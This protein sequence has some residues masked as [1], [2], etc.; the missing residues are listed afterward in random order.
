[1]DW[2]RPWKMP[3]MEAITFRGRP[4]LSSDVVW[5]ALHIM[6]NSVLDWD[7]DVSWV[8]PGLPVRDKHPW[9][10]FSLAEMMEVLARSLGWSAPGPDH[11][12]WTH[13]K[14]LMAWEEV[15]SLLLWIANACLQMG[16]WLKELKAFKTVVILKPGKPSYNVP[17]TFR[18]I[19]L[20]NMMDKLFEKTIANWL[21][22]EAA[23]EGILHPCQFRGV[24]Q[25][26]TENTEIYLTHLVH[27]E[28]AKG[29]KT[30]MVAFDLAQYFSSLQHRVIITLLKYMGFATQ[31][32]DFFADYL[33]G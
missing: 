3:F 1:M 28:W 13:L 5:S 16:T 10:D 33:V 23:K 9:L 29:L 27:T 11:L 25:N 19:I 32:C 18:P 12:T 6:F 30:S 22:F 26:S 17:K 21:Q 20:L 15:A 31:V 4:C 2:I 24:C 8:F 7:T 14:C